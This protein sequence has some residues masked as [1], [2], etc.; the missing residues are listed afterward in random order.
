MRAFFRL[1]RLRAAR[2]QHQQ[3]FNRSTVVM[4]SSSAAALYTAAIAASKAP[5]STPEDAADKSHHQ[6]GGVGFMNPWPSYVD[7]FPPKLLWGMVS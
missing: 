1:S 6:K 5:A 7:F 3:R 4:S 2:T